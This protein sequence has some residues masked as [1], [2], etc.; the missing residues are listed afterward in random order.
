VSDENLPGTGSVVTLDALAR[1]F[2]VLSAT[3][4]AAKTQ[5]V[6]EKTPAEA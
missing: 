3:N 4:S 2:I 1:T 5:R 6:I